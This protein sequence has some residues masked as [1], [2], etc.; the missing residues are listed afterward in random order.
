[1]ET[2]LLR[3]Q[4]DILCA[5]DNQCSVILVLFDL[6]A[7]FDTVNHRILLKRLATRFGIG[8]LALEW[9]RSYLSNCKSSFSVEGA[10][11]TSRSLNCGVPQGS[12]LGPILFMLYTSPI[13]DVVRNHDINFHLYA[14]D[15]QLYIT[16]STSSVSQIHS[17]KLKL[18]VDGAEWTEHEWW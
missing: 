3:V 13:G 12:V 7:A 15:S 10:T 4:N 6:S 14:D 2:A 11:S 1:M 16:F 9:F 18:E 17:A 5:I 8:G